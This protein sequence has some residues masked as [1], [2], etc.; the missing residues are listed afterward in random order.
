MFQEQNSK[1]MS[2]TFNIYCDESTHLPNDGHP[3]MILGYVSIAANQMKLA[4]EQIKAIKAKHNYEGELKWTNVHEATLQM[5]VEIVEYFFMT[6]MQFRAV[7]VDKSQIDE[8]RRDYT[9][10]DFY[11]R[12]YYQLL[13]HKTDMEN[14]YNV[15]IDIKDTCSNDKLRQLEEII[16]WNTAIRRFQFVKSSES[17]FLQLADVI[18]G[19]INYN[20]RIEKGEIEGKVIAKRKIVEK[21][22]GHNPFIS[23]KC[24]TPLSNRKFNLF[25]I[26]LK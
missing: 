3:H 16:K 13:H 8:T 25:F 4:K 17:S 21:I 10:N 6:D 23:L 14:N 1:A 12:M 24:S 22:K 20:L 7:I 9:F 26:S 11:F 2:K 18:I 5:Y 15:Y 19:A